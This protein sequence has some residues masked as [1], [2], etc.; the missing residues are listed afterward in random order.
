MSITNQTNTECD[1]VSHRPVAQFPQL[2][3]PAAA[4]VPARHVTGAEV[5]SEH[6]YPSIHVRQVVWPVALLY[7]PA[8][9]S[10][11][12]DMGAVGHFLPGAG[13]YNTMKLNILPMH[14]NLRR[15]GKHSDDFN[16][17]GNSFQMLG[18]LHLVLVSNNTAMGPFKCYVTLFSWKL[19]PHPPSRNANNIELYTFAT[20]SPEH[21]TPLTHLRYVTIEWPQ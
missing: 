11:G 18:R 7:S 5:L 3:D 13:K 21:L 19:Y 8:G 4:Y 2:V 15:E 6:W 16:V 1:T 20:F 12:T 17:V 9:Q 10:W 14:H